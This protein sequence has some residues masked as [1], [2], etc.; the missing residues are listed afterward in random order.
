MKTGT[1]SAT[2]SSWK[3]ELGCQGARQTGNDVIT[4]CFSPAS[5]QQVII[6]LQSMRNSRQLKSTVIGNLNR[7]L[8]HHSMQRPLFP[9][10]V[11]CI[12]A[13]YRESSRSYWGLSVYMYCMAE[14]QNLSYEASQT[15]NKVTDGFSNRDFLLPVCW[16]FYAVRYHREVIRV[17]KWNHNGENAKSAARGRL[18]P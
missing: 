8:R 4:H 17:W 13:V 2:Y 16:Q 18:R 9:I 10:S 5:Y 1:L 11:Q 7:K 15:G 12:L 6:D 14:T 3:R